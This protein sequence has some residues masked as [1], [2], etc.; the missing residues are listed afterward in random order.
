MGTLYEG[1]N[2]KGRGRVGNLVYYIRNGK[3]I[4]RKIG[5]STK[6]PSDAQKENRL[7][8][9]ISNAFCMLT[10]PFID[11]GFAAQV[12]GRDLSTFNVAV[13]YNKMNAIQGEY[14]NL[15][16]DYSRVL[17]AEGSLLQADD[18]QV[19]IVETGLEFSWHVAPNLQWPENTDQVMLLAIFPN[20]EKISYQP[21]GAS[22]STGTAVLEIS[23]PMLGEYIESYIA[24]IS[25]D[26]KTVSSSVY[27]GSLNR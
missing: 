12:V 23:G 26:R 27:V 9:K 10:R 11:Y 6:P 4:V 3:Q 1:I 7:R 15:S 17:L 25:A 20:K 16:L 24:F 21:F 19:K 22:R 2:G 13:S 18:V 5:V 14:P 8:M